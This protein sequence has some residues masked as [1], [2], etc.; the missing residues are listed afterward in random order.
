MFV[1]FYG[2][3]LV[4]DIFLF[5]FLISITGRFINQHCLINHKGVV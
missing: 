1:I 5:L 2:L 3:F 4:R